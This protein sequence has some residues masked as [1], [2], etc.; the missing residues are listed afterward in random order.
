L[1]QKLKAIVNKTHQ[2]RYNS[3]DEF[4][5]R[6]LAAID[7][8]RSKKKFSHLLKIL[9]RQAGFVLNEGQAQQMQERIRGVPNA[10]GLEFSIVVL[11][12]TRHSPSRVVSALAE[13]T[14]PVYRQRAAFP[15]IEAPTWID[16][17]DWL[18]D[19]L[20]KATAE[21]E[22]TADVGRSIFASLLRVRDRE[23]YLNALLLFA[24]LLAGKGRKNA[25]SEQSELEA[26][27][28]ELLARPKLNRRQ[29]GLIGK[30]G[31]SMRDAVD[32]A[33]DQRRQAISKTDTLQDEIARLRTEMQLKAEE[34]E[35]QARALATLQANLTSAHQE[36]AAAHGR[37]AG[38]EEHWNVVSKQQLAGV[39]SKLKREIEHEMK[40][41]LFSLDRAL[42]NTE[43]AIQRVRRVQRILEKA[44]GTS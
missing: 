21:K 25:F 38:T 6:F 29:V 20:S 16:I 34:S 9:T 35:E 18:K 42:P 13:Q 36:L 24:D 4:W 28:A 2:D 26:V 37:I 10:D 39:L 15:D 11:A 30:S 44:D 31:R 22:D 41:I 17:R 12:R 8:A 3:F 40:E 7:L 14:W 1:E 33:L 43:M 5:P 23:F 19:R 27:F 32:L